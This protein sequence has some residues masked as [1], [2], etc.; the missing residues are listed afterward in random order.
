MEQKARRLARKIETRKNEQIAVQKEAYLQA[1]REFEEKKVKEYKNRTKK[2]NVK[3]E[4]K[5]C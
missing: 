1:I 3:K 5:S 4:K 2:K